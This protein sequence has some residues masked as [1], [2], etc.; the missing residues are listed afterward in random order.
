[1][2]EIAKRLAARPVAAAVATSAAAVPDAAAFLRVRSDSVEQLS[3][4]AGE[5]A[6]ARS[7]IEAEMRNLKGGLC[8]T[9][10]P[11]SC[12]C[13]DNCV[14]SKFRASHKFSRALIRNRNS[15]RWSSTVTH[16]SRS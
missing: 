8:L 15:T 10:P 11:R 2:A 4:E 1:M 3:D 9:S 16:D 13:A 12:V 6:I 14:R 5:I 7:R